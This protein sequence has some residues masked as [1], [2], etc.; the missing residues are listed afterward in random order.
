[1]IHYLPFFFLFFFVNSLVINGLN[2]AAG[3]KEWV[4]TAFSWLQT[5]DG[6]IVVIAIQYDVLFSRGEAVWH[7]NLSWICILMTFPMI[8]QLTLSTIAFRV[9]IEKTGNI[10]LASFVNSIFIA[11]MVVANTCTISSL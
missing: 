6:I 9:F 8:L 11:M 1:M 7:P 10:Y 5:L 3:Q 4:N 2:R